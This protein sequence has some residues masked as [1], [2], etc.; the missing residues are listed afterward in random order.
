MATSVKSSNIAKRLN[1][2]GFVGHDSDLNDV[3]G[4][5]FDEKEVDDN[6]YDADSE[7]EDDF[8]AAET[9]EEQPVQLTVPSPTPTASDFASTADGSTS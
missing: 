2:F 1:K 3:L 7:E 5:Y 8:Y 9:E 6:D 4:D